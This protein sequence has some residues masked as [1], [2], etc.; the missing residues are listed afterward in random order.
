[1]RHN[2]TDEHSERVCSEAGDTLGKTSATKIKIQ[3]DMACFFLEGVLTAL[4]KMDIFLFWRGVRACQC[5][6]EYLYTYKNYD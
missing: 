4:V 3:M 2:A 1:M 5:D 6:L